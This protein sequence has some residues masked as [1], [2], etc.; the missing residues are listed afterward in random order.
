MDKCLLPTAMAEAAR[1]LFCPLSLSDDKRCEMKP[2]LLL[3]FLHRLSVNVCCHSRR[4]K[5][6]ILCLK[7]VYQFQ[8]AKECT[9]QTMREKNWQI[10]KISMRQ[11]LTKSSTF[12]INADGKEEN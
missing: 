10:W 3:F 5:P 11:N 12:Y 8:C 9:K 6:L 2:L 7:A 1:E 4:I